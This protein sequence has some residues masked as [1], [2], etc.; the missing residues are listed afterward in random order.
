MN[1]QTAQFTLTGSMDVTDP[2]FNTLVT[3]PTLRLQMEWET[4]GSMHDSFG[5][6]GRD[7]VSLKTTQKTLKFHVTYFS[8]DGRWAYPPTFAGSCGSPKGLN[9]RLARGQG[10]FAGKINLKLECI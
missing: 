5:I 9:Q 3:N 2:A 10:T 4:Q 1:R 7:E 6:V 8:A